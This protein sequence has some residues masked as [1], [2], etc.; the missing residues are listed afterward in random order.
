MKIVSVEMLWLIKPG[1]KEICMLHASLSVTVAPH[2]K[3][4]GQLLG[5]AT[6]FAGL[7][8]FSSVQWHDVR[9]F[10]LHFVCF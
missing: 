2:V 6:A 10:C 1:L 3:G 7:P 4:T 8:C 5:R 9:I